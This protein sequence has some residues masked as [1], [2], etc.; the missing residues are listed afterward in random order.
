MNATKIRQIVGWSLI[1]ILLLWIALNFKSVPVHL[2][3]GEVSMPVAFV[4]M[5]S[6][7]AGAGAVFAFQYLRKFKKSDNSPKA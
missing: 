5:L 7:A 1:G 3:I 6:A 2:L 4:I